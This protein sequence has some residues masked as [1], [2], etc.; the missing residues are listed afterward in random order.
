MDVNA[1]LS[2]KQIIIA[3]LVLFGFGLV[4][5]PLQSVVLG[6]PLLGFGCLFAI[7]LVW[8]LIKKKSMKQSPS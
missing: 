1:K 5:G 7:L 3:I 4:M 8:W 6:N 2:G